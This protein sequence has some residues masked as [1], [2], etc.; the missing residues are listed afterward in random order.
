MIAGAGN[1]W[2]RVAAIA[3]GLA[4]AAWVLYCPERPDRVFRALPP[5][6]LLVTEH[7]ELARGWS[8][9]LGNPV[10]VQILEG[11]GVR[12]AGELATD[13]NTVRIVRLVTGKRSL[14][15][16][17][18]ALG[19][20]ETPTW[21]G[22]SFVGLRGRI[23]QLMLWARWIPGAGRLVRSPGGSLYLPLHA[24][25]GSDGPEVALAFALRENV[26]L[27]TLG[28]DPDAVRV[29]DWRL[30]R[31]APLGP[32][33]GTGEPWSLP[34]AGPMRGWLAAEAADAY[35]PLRAPLSFD[36]AAWS[37]AKIRLDLRLQPADPAWQTWRLVGRCAMLDA[38][39]DDPPR[40][41]LVAPA[42]PVRRLL[43]AW[44]PGVRAS[45]RPAAG[46]E[47][48][49]CAYLTNQ[50]YGGRFFGIALPAAHLLMP[51]PAA[52]DAR[53]VPTLID[54]ANRRF[55]LGL[56]V[57]D[58]VPPMADRTLVDSARLG[59]LGRTRDADC[60]AVEQRP[61]WL[62]LASAA[63]SLDAQRAAAVTGQA[64][65]RAAWQAACAQPE[66]IGLLWLDAPA[67]AQEASRVMTVYR[68]VASL[69][70]RDPDGTQETRLQKVVD[71][72]HAC[73]AAGRVRVMAGREGAWLAVRVETAGVGASPVVAP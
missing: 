28:P 29:L 50:A 24:S 56:A 44:L 3:L 15:G 54:A 2:A 19:P 45:A 33:F 52:P 55:R 62:R 37:P 65:W 23:F 8:D 32:V 38:L 22:A 18:P 10:L 11:F 61:G 47:Q 73:A 20:S 5:N 43:E 14:I 26:L 31:D 39:A 35:V 1:R 13:T 9:R 69:S 4:A 51:W 41:L 67:V 27:A 6:C 30:M 68:L 63:G 17:S 21:V 42:G 12:K 71:A 60:L 46:E 34:L 49:T 72:L 64:D 59:V 53:L 25:E 48:D 70:R 66:P 57:R 16:W 58:S 7:D 40:V 36:V